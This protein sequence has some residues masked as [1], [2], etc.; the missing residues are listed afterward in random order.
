MLSLNNQFMISIFCIDFFFRYFSNLFFQ[1][2]R[3]YPS[4]A[5]VIHTLP[6]KDFFRQMDASVVD[7][8]RRALEDYVT[9]IVQRLPT[10]RTCFMSN[11]CLFLFLPLFMFTFIRLS[12]LL[13]L[14]L[15]TF[16]TQFFLL[17][18][19]VRFYGLVTWMSS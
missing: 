19:N 12:L 6:E 2:R 14:F 9:R 7:K 5:S 11:L 3:S 13:L 15:Y 17:M 4:Q 8:R 10:V 1:L 16:I 18:W